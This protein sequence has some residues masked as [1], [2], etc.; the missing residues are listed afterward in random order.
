MALPDLTPQQRAEALEK[1]TRARR[2][3][4][5]VKN[6]LKSREL[7]LSEVI[8]MAA[9]DEAI[10]KMKV[11]SLLEALPRVGVSTAEALMNEIKIAPSRRVR[12]L[13]QV[14]RGTDS[15]PR[16][17]FR[18]HCGSIQACLL[19]KLPLSPAQRLSAKAPLLHVCVSV[20][21]K[22]SFQSQ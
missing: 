6:A 19:P 18:L 22:L 4:A 10:A 20:F 13:G 11:R 1:A 5:E 9:S 16:L 21:L 7:T 15:P 17:K 2:R 12:G 14:Q 3:R 8:D